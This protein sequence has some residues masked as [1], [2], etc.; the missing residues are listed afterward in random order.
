MLAKLFEVHRGGA[1]VRLAES[2]EN[3]MF[4]AAGPGGSLIL[5]QGQ[6][7]Q[8]DVAKLFFPADGRHIGLDRED[9]GAPDSKG[10]AAVWWSRQAALVLALHDDTRRA[11]PEAEVLARKCIKPRAPKR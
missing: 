7:K 10:F 8:A 5:T 11:L 9:F 3:I 2:I 4:L 6:N 1:P